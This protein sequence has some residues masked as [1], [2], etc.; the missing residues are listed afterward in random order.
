MVKSYNP[1]AAIL[2][3]AA[4]LCAGAA[5]AH[6]GVHAQPP[7][8]EASPWPDRV[9]LTFETDPAR[10]LAVSWR[11][12]AL[13]SAPPAQIALATADARFDVTA[14]T[15]TAETEPLDLQTLRREG[16]DIG[17]PENAGLAPVHYHSVRFDGLEPDTLYAY[18][19]R[20]AD[21][22]W[23]EWFQTRTAP[24][25][26]PVRF[27]YVG[28][29]QNGIL[30]H[31]SRT[32][33]AAF[34]AAPDARFIL[35][36]GDLVNRG[37]R[38][39]EWAEWFKALGFIHGMIPAIPVAGNHEYSNFG[40][41]P[42]TAQRTLSIMWRPQFRLPVEESLPPALRETVYDVRYTRDLHIFVLDTMNAELEVQARWLDAELSRTDAKWRV[43]S[44]H[45]P[46]FSSAQGR[47]SP[48]LREILL[49]VL[50][51]HKVD[52][53]LQGH[54]HTYARG[55]IGDDGAQTPERSAVGRDG[56]LAVMFATSVSGAKQYNFKDKL[57]ADYAP[58]EVE[59]LRHAENTQFFQV[60]DVEG[61]TLNYRAYTVTGELY[62]SVVISKDGAGR[63]TVAS[64]A[65]STIGQRMFEGTGPY[66][67]TDDLR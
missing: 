19:V 16:V 59:L 53:V 37:S 62:D 17:L 18:R 58:S 46:V 42:E 5:S 9:T 32:I 36:A 23:S 64:G 35:H 38:D 7:W 49:P 24:L 13:V 39:F 25:S 1:V 43:V 54:D 27:I 45:H 10:S 14:R 15:F 51:K 61:D 8:Q 22:A 41:T 6:E 65:P 33:R 40:L 67:G 44:M 63:K 48:R 55:A 12:N 56:D 28:D 50:L 66:P 11:T 57:W 47:D 26:G 31:W 20:G 4:V 29:A 2:A 34:Q 30:S 21:G 52:F 60:I 3:A